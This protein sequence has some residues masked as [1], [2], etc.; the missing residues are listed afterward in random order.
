MS[1]D[2][3]E[4]ADKVQLHNS[5]EKF[6]MDDLEQIIRWVGDDSVINDFKFWDFRF[7]VEDRWYPKLGLYIK[8]NAPDGIT[9]ILEEWVTGNACNTIARGMFTNPQSLRKAVKKVMKIARR[10]MDA[11][12]HKSIESQKRWRTIRSNFKGATK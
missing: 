12:R 8:V 11:S 5:L 2:Y 3:R 10:K 9:C 4:M 1:E 6:T 7:S